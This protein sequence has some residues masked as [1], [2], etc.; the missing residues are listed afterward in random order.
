MICD[1]GVES[2]L[3]FILFHSHVQVPITEKIGYSSSCFFNGGRFW[4]D[5]SEKC[6]EGRPIHDQRSC[7]WGLEAVGTG[8]EYSLVTGNS[9][10]CLSYRRRSGNRVSRR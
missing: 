5:E 3:K 8:S 4:L 1:G 2:R 7:H 6:L 9:T 10:G